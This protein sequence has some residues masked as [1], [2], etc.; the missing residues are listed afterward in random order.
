MAADI[1]AMMPLP[2]FPYDACHKVATRVSSTSLVRYKTNDYSVPTRFGHLEVLV[3]GYV[4]RVDIVCSG[5]V[6]ASHVRS[7]GTADFIYNPPLII[8]ALS[9]AFGTQD[10]GTGPSRPTGWLELSRLYR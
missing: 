4:D 5:K 10:Q 8:N 1:G 9:G 2:A 3:K 7:Y 6:I